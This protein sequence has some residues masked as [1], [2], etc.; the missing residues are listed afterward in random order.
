M[1]LALGQTDAKTKPMEERFEK[2]I[3][4]CRG[5]YDLI[6]IDCHPA[7]SLFTKTSLRNSD[8]VLIPVVP[9]SQYA[10]RGIGL[11]MNFIKAKKI[12]EKSPAPHILLNMTQRFGVSQTENRIRASPEVAAFC[13]SES[14]KRYKA[15]SEPEG[16]SG[17]VWGSGKPYST[18]AFANLI[19]VAREILSRTGV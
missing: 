14:L 8:H 2:F 9:E 11:M 18:E 15:F 7:G 4:E 10:L 1:Y 6:V 3:T 13:M 12:G 5:K 16:G 19:L 17:F